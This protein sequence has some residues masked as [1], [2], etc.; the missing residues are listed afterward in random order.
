[1][2]S[3]PEPLEPGKR[4]TRLAVT[5][6]RRK[7]AR[8]V[9]RKQYVPYRQISSLAY[10]IR[11]GSRYGEELLVP[12][13]CARCA[14][15]SLD[16]I[17]WNGP[18]QPLCEQC[19]D[20]Q[21]PSE[22][23]EPRPRVRGLR[24]GTDAQLQRFA[25][26]RGICVEALETAQRMGTARVGIVCGHP[27]IVLMDQ[28]GRCMEGRRLDNL[29]YPAIGG[30]PE[31]KAHTIANSCKAWPVGIAPYG[32]YL[33]RC[34][35]VALVEGGPDYFAA[36]HFAHVF[37]ATGVVPAAVLSRAVTG[38][39]P[40]SNELFRG[41]RVRIFPH[42]DPDGRSYRSALNWGRQLK[43]LGCEVDFFTF[44]ELPAKDLNDCTQVPPEQLKG[45]FS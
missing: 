24:L 43:Q 9:R 41:K 44:K 11:L 40:G 12:F 1:M 8:L 33:R 19:A 4:A 29:K 7:T 32:Q 22:P 14:R 25:D 45:I 38:F 10:P 39:H 2:A 42:N 28:S 16:P 18:H 21:R 20:P 23:P 31:R 17:G 6:A 15:P 13:I 5:P 34:E 27:S 36:L 37:G 35:L 26:N 30:L 3:H